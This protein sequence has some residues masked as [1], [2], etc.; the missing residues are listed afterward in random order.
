VRV[1]IVGHNYREWMG[2][3]TNLDYELEKSGFELVRRISVDTK[4]VLCINWTNKVWPILKEANLMGIPSV[5]VITEPGVIL[6]GN[7]SSKVRNR[8][9]QIIEV[10]RPRGLASIKYPVEWDTS[11][12]YSSARLPRIAAISS[13]K[14]SLAAGELYS[15][16]ALAYE[17]LENLD[18]YGY[19]WNISRFSFFMKSL[20]EIGFTL[21]VNKALGID[22]KKLFSISQPRP[23]NY[24]GPVSSKFETL[25]KYKVSLVIENSLEYMSEKLLHSILSG[26]IPVYVGPNPEEFGIPSS[27]V[28]SAEPDI[29]DLKSK[30][31]L[32]LE[33]SHDE[34]RK[35]AKK[36]LACKSLEQ[37]W[38][39]SKL[40]LHIIKTIK[41]VVS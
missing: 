18:L 4:A 30:V 29:A 6:P 5:L 34:W 24:R 9:D 14:F 38:N 35:E 10:G 11:F 41:N 36:W 19:D 27:L 20:R 12:V 32:A 16:R 26:A 37:S 2:E 8:F 21:L 1:L 22:W 31:N 39:G 3:P 28:V 23:L 40:N 7:S 15:L 33:L 17:S 25:A 13:N